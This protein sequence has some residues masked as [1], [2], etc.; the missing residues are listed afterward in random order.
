VGTITQHAESHFLFKT[1][2]FKSLSVVLVL[3]SSVSA[4]KGVVGGIEPVFTE[5]IGEVESFEVFDKDIFCDF[6]DSGDITTLIDGLSGEEVFSGCVSDYLFPPSAI[7]RFDSPVMVALDPKMEVA[8]SLD[9]FIVGL[10][11]VIELFK[12]GDVAPNLTATNR[13]D[14]V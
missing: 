6:F 11:V 3:I 4:Y 5:F 1:F 10:F 8:S 12:V 14:Q 2:D 9:H 13:Y 7:F